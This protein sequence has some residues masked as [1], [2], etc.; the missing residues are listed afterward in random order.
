VVSGLLGLV[1][2]VVGF[3]FVF[4]ISNVARVG[5]VN[6]VGH[7]LGTA[8][9]KSHAVFSSSSITI[10]V[11]VGT[12]VSV[13]VV[14]SNGISVVVHWG[15]IISGF[16]I[17][18]SRVGGFVCGSW[19]GS[20]FVSGSWVRS[21]LVDWGRGRVVDGS[22]FVGRGMVDGGSVVDRGVVDG[23]GWVVDRGMV[24]RGVVWSHWVGSL[25]VLS[26]VEGI[27]L[28][29]GSGRVFLFVTV[30]VDLIGGGSGLRVDSGSIVTMSTV[31]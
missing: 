11:F 1:G 18:G 9:G 20:G 29:S 7:N 25:G 17:S 31:D 6:T 4:D 14:I 28:G 27:S 24:D 22:G 21:W 5:I 30:L 19:V 8:I 16:M 26:V 3:T 10:T 13:R 12:K 15:S 2:S 23:L